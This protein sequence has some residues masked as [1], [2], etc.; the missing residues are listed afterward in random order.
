M[1]AEVDLVLDLL[2]CGLSYAQ[3]AQKFDV[4]KSCIQKIADGSRRSQLVAR[5][6]RVSVT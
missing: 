5:S 2:A 4:S 6:V 3:V 1:D